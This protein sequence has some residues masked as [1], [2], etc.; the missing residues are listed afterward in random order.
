M[1]P[2]VAKDIL[3]GQAD[4]LDSSYHISYN[5]LLNMMRV[6]GADP[7]FLVRSSF[8]QYQQQQAA[9]GLEEEAAELAAQAAAI[10]VADEEEV[11]EYHRVSVQLRRTEAEMRQ[12]IMMP[13]KALPF[14]QIGRLVKLVTTEPDGTQVDWGWGVIV[15]FRR[16]NVVR[17]GG[18]G[19][20]VPAA[21]RG[22]GVAENSF[23]VECIVHC[24]PPSAASAAGGSGGGGSGKDGGGQ[25]R[26][27]VAGEKSEPRV[28]PFELMDIHTLSAIKMSMPPTD[29]R[30]S[31]RREQVMA[32]VKEFF[33]RSGGPPPPIDPVKDMG[34]TSGSFKKLQERSEELSE[35]LRMRPF[36][37]AV[38]CDERYGSYLMKLELQE[39]AK[40]RRREARQLM[41]TTMSDNLKHM[42]R[43]LRRLGHCDA[44]DVIQLK[45]RVA[46]EVRCVL[47]W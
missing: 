8:H 42:K 5:M 17:I 24:A 20:P 10:T 41:N 39:R 36:H 18:R 32:S 34:I 43:V 46:C 25:P 21:A 13:E 14:I 28:V 45:G 37:T 38:D 11:M 19:A 9:P 26:P 30:E 47:F 16:R 3:Y 1:D 2:A 12:T 29:L 35:R 23:E 33:R 4:P 6:E 27:A 40:A 7:E 31:S 15:N 44:N 22:N